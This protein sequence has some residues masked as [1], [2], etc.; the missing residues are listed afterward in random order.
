M[1][2]LVGEGALVRLE[3]AD[4]EFALPRATRQGEADRAAVFLSRRLL[5]D[6]SSAFDVR[7]AEV[8]AC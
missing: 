2:E 3:E 6:Y 7:E 1:G 8:F 4:L 5:E